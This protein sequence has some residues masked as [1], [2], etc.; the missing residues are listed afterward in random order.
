[1]LSHTVQSIESVFCFPYLTTVSVVLYFA[2]AVVRTCSTGVVDGRR[3]ACRVP[4]RQRHF[5]VPQGHSSAAF[6]GRAMGVT[7]HSF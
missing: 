5:P 2:R 4:P 6:P 7:P 3:D 1:M